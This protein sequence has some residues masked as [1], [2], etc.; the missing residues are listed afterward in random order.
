[1][2]R[3]VPTG[4]RVRRLVSWCCEPSQPQRIISGLKTIFSLKSAF[5]LFIPQF[6]ISQVSLFVQTAT[7]I[8]STVSERKPRKAV[9]CVFE[10]IYIPQALNT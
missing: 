9:A 10:L 5:Y 3:G 6:I 7:Q 2:L 4:E 1:M 8:I